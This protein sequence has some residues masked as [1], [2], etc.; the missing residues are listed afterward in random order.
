MMSTYRERIG[1]AADLTFIVAVV[2]MVVFLIARQLSPHGDADTRLVELSVSAPSPPNTGAVVVFL[3]T[4]CVH[5]TSSW[6]GVSHVLVI[7]V[8]RRVS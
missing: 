5:C 3:N 7:R 6:Y 1:W 4:N 8:S 2:A